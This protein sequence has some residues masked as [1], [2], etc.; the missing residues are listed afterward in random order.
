MPLHAVE[1][2]RTEQG[3]KGHYICAHQCLFGRNTLLVLEDIR[4]VTSTV[5]LRLKTD[6]GKYQGHEKFEEIGCE[7]YFETRVFHAK[8]GNKFND[9]DIEK[10]IS[11]NS[12]WRINKIDGEIEANQMH[13]D[14]VSEI[15]TK[16]Q[17][18]EFNVTHN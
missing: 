13:E 9:P 3:W 12:Q 14:V 8:A 16:I 15:I 1:I 6:H 17:G 2:K 18:G 7:T 11:F 5:G 10:E 4:I